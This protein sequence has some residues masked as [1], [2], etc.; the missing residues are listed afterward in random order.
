M[1]CSLAELLIVVAIIAV[2]VAISIPIFSGQLEKARE[3]T[4]VA[5]IRAAYA[6]AV[7]AALESTDGTGSAD[8]VEM[9]QTVSGW[10]HID[11]K[12]ASKYVYGTDI[13]A[14]EKGDTIKISIDNTGAVTFTKN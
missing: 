7:T 5:N 12:L 9:T 6:E 10:D 8:T 13:P 11:G 1:I 4:D 3:A 14:V 2:L